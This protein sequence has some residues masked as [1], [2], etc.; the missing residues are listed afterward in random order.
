[1]KQL[2]FIIIGAQK[3]A[4]TSLFK[5][6]IEHP[7]IHMPRDK[8]A[9]F[10][11]HEKLYSNG[12]KKFTQQ[13]FKNAPENKLWGTAT[14]QYMGDPRAAQ[15]IAKQNPNTRLI[16]I[17]RNPIERTYSH[18]TMSVRREIETR[19]FD[20]TVHHLLKDEHL[21]QYRNETPPE[22]ENGYTKSST[23]DNNFYCV[24]SEY[25]R[26]LSQY[27]T[28]FPAEQMLV[29]YMDELMNEPQKSINKVIH[30]LGFKNSFT[31]DNLG[32][33]YH[34][35][36]NKVL[37]PN[38]WKESIKQNFIFRLIW[39]RIPSETRGNINYWYEQMNIRKNKEVQGPSKTA[40]Q[41][42][43]N[44]F[45]SDIKQLENLTKSCVPWSEF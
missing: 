27:R 24:W 32:K 22:H 2:D 15:R 7:D 25:G 45:S 43:M 31:P 11:S 28:F 44:H 38:A 20:E 30:F 42:L 4:T 41:L 19:N 16:A 12:W 39:A 6:L 10:F 5:Y 13:Y 1:M 33:K 8:E 34:Q 18:Y 40:R 37:I 21:E 29:L 35:G 3:S 36:G 9:P 23:K 26:I 14:P 17:L